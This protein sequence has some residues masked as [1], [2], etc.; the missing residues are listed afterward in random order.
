M[1]IG[2]GGR[3]SVV[4]VQLPRLRRVVVD[5][6]TFRLNSGGGGTL[7]ERA[8]QPH[9]PDTTRTTQRVDDSRD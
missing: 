1:V 9:S 5:N 8:V 3:C 6:D 2:I 4:V 7:E